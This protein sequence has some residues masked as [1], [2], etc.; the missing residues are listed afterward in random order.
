MTPTDEKPTILLL[1]LMIAHGAMGKAEP[2]ARYV[3]AG[4]VEICRISIF[5]I[6]E[7]DV[8]MA[9]QP[10][11]L[12]CALL[13]LNA[14]AWSGFR[15]HMVLSAAHVHMYGSMARCAET[16][17]V[18]WKSREFLNRLAY[19]WV[20]FDQEL[21]LFHDREP[22]FEIDDCN[23][24]IPSNNELWS[25]TSLESWQTGLQ[26]IH[27]QNPQAASSSHSLAQ[28]FNMF[29]SNELSHPAITLSSIE[30]RLLLQP[31]QASIY[32]TNKSLQYSFNP[33]YKL[34]HIH[35]PTAKMH[36]MLQLLK[37][38][39]FTG[40]PYPTSNFSGQTI[41]ITG[42]N[43]GLGLEA[44]RHIARLGAS[45]VILAVRTIAKGEAA[46]RDII[47]STNAKENVVEVWPLDL[48]DFDSIKAFGDRVQ[49]LERLDAL[50]QNAG[51]LTRHFELVQ[52]NES[53]I[54]IN[55]IS[56]TLVGL[57]VLP[58]L[59]E[60]SQKFGVRARL[61][62]VGSDLQ[63]IAKYKEGET[64]G[65]ILEALAKKEGVDM[66][67]RYNVSKL[68]LL[69]T[70]R[71][72]AARVPLS[73]ESNVV[74]TKMTPGACQSDLFRDDTGW[75]E[76]TI[77]SIL[78]KLVARTTEVGSRTLVHSV[79]PDLEGNAHGAFLMDCR[80]AQ[81]GSRVDSAKGQSEQ[82][83]WIEE[84]LPKLESIAPGCT[85]ALA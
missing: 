41:V 21:S 40:I 58:K 35:A 16:L 66:K 43:T 22:D 29:M 6:L 78:M 74:I 38:Q 68:L 13:Y 4:L 3:A 65:S 24:L 49:T 15:W 63:Y 36:F 82:K 12:R 76:A 5:D 61:S 72:L 60:T 25:A 69:Y 27:W 46:A 77:Q 28:L 10:M 48:S 85:N 56:A 9:A 14:A 32:H 59:Q 47:A 67:D 11:M 23:A 19:S 73:K 83:R 64:S 2:K 20:T 50:I 52:G 39:L 31:L 79:K 7:K 84:L 53:H 18:I 70:V 54:T 55:V 45:K 44:A 33:V 8:Q 34:Q 51:I 37:S 26:E 57:L 75:L 30:L 71:E 1:L 42:S 62:F 80:V 17:W 81:N